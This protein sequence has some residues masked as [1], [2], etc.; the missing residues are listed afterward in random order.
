MALGHAWPSQVEERP[1][2]THFRGDHVTFKDGSSERFDAVIFCTGYL[3]AYP[4]LAKDLR[5][6]EPNRMFPTNL[7]KVCLFVGKG[8]GEKLSYIGAQRNC[9]YITTALDLQAREGR[10]VHSG[11]KLYEI[12]A[13]IP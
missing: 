4:F 6:E 2:L 5:I 10:T 1:L 9:H 7:Y 11:F 3:H 13:F 8:G 12:D